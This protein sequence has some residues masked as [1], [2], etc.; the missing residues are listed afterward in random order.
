M[1]FHFRLKLKYSF[2]TFDFF[3]LPR[4]FVDSDFYF[5]IFRKFHTIFRFG[6]IFLVKVN[7][8]KPFESTFQLN[9]FEKKNDSFYKSRRIQIENLLMHE[10]TTKTY[11]IVT[12]QL[13]FLIRLVVMC[14]RPLPLPS[15]STISFIL[16]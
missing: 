12:T 8:F 4:H 15:F 3:S 1:L 6:K 13:E 14:T 5:F 11:N 10:I 2:K 9:S 7:K 16:R